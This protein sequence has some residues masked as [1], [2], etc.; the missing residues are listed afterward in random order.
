[1]L[2]FG[3][4]AL[5]LPICGIAD[6]HEKKA[7]C[8]EGKRPYRTGI[9][10]I[11]SGG[12]GYENGYTT[13]EAFLSSDP[14]QWTI[15][16]FLDARA[17]VFDNGKWAA[18][19]GIGLRTL[20]ANRAY[21]INTYY[22]YR[23][24]GRL[25]ANQIGLGLETLG[26]LL[27]FR[28]NGYLPLGAKMSDPYDPEFRAFS[29]HSLLVWQKYHSAMKGADA[30]LGFHFFHTDSF[31]FY[32]GVGP[33][34]FIG[35]VAPPIWGAKARIA[36][37]F[38]DTLTLEISDSYDR[39][40]KNK[41][42]GQIGFSFSFGPK[43]TVKKRENSCTNA[44]ALNDRM[45]QPI[46]R[47]EII[48]IDNARKK[49]V[50][51]DPDTGLPYFFVFVDNTSSSEGTYQSPYPTFIQAQDNSSP[52]DILY[53]F[54]GDGTTTGMDSGIAL[55]A[56]QKLWGSGVSHLLPTPAGTLKIPAQSSSA[57]TI[58]NTNA[59]T[60]GNAVTL[61]TNNSISGFTID[62]PLFDAIF[63]SNAQTLEVTY[64]TFQNTT[65]FPIEAYF[66]GDAF[67]S[68]ANNLFLNNTNGIFLELNGTSTVVCSGNT[69]EGQTSTSN[70]PIEIT[71]ANNS[72]AAQ[73]VNNRFNDNTTGSIRFNLD[74]V[75]DS[76]IFCINNTISNNGTG[77]SSTLGSSFV[78]IP[79][80]TT[81]YC[82][83]VLNNNTFSDNTSNGLYLHTS[84]AFTTLEI[85]ASSNTITNIGGSATVIGTP[86]NTLTFLAESNT[87]AGVHDHAMTIPETV[88]E[89][90]KIT[91][92]NNTISNVGSTQSGI[93]IAHEGTNL[94]LI[95]TNNHITDC[96]GSGIV[97]YS[98]EFTNMQTT[99][100]GNTISNCQNLGSNLGS[101]IS[102]ARYVNFTGKIANNIFA[103]NTNGPSLDMQTDRP[104]PSVC[105]NLTNNTYNI[106]GDI[107]YQFANPVDGVFNL[108]PCD[109]DTINIGTISSTGAITTV[110]SCQEITPCPP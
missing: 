24:T 103:D 52:N 69:I 72:F 80:G 98:N 86:I 59:D 87:I 78:I 49:T 107:T 67:A 32:S 29:G 95:I 91:I 41:F 106:P 5:A 108:S 70:V 7:N 22:D 109:A 42:Q 55:Q 34:Y 4:L 81:D 56:N 97:C 19:A 43:S 9:R 50:A 46:S 71:A 3:F 39:T 76:S 35:K 12:I 85:S 66:S 36:A 20:L 15:L 51:I 54:P 6:I 23:D 11:E 57:P 58:T 65:R 8:P 96:E 74:N 2:R 60:E 100:T 102:I 53:V 92:D 93:A 13:L 18:N 68:I 26:E 73:I 64:C 14:S 104:S 10:H 94:N 47:N 75:A 30:E 101:G 31:D 37:T 89:T 44:V 27:D 99:I 45:L 83:I 40:F 90:A 1:M 77:S 38:K 84:G 48:V 28:I 16:P 21:G 61:A 110:Q 82:S 62:S 25:N 17:H 88:I 105:L 63:G 33:Y 79:T